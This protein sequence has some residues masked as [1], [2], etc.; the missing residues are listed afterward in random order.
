MKEADPTGWQQAVI[1]R[2]EPRTARMRSYY[3]QA[4][5]ARHVAGQHVDVRLTA[6]DGY[7]ARR[8]YSIASAPGAAELELAIDLMPDGEVSGFFHEVARPGDTIEVRGPLG[9]HFVWDAAQAG[10]VLLIGGGSGVVPLVS[11][12]RAWRDAGGPAPAL[13]MHSAR[14]WDGLAFR[15]ELADIAVN[16]PRFQ[17]E[18]IV[19]RGAAPQGATRRLDAALLNELLGRWGHAPAVCYVCGANPFVEAAAQLL[20]AKG[21]P[22][23]SVRTERYGG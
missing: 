19:T 9:G 11:I 20:V 5:M 18:T 15:D 13:L 17:Y 10:A 6:P 12:A 7:Q 14:T 22:P 23:R 16:H 1:T 21:V 2:I 8:S 3:L 4:P